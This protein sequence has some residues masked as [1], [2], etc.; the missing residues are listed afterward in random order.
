MALGLFDPRPIDARMRIWPPIVWPLM[1]IASLLILMGGT[2]NGRPGFLIAGGVFAVAVLVIAVYLAV[3]D[4]RDGRP[5]HPA[6]D[7]AMLGAAL[8]YVAIAAAASIAGPEYGLAGIAAGVIPLAALGLL[9]AT[10]RHKTVA[11]P[12]GLRDE[13]ADKEDDPFPGIGIDEGTPLGDSPQHAAPD[14]RP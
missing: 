4:R 5:K 12:G 14:R 7:R 10:V 9:T 8:F 1:S 2:G 11:T 13:S 3:G 6:M